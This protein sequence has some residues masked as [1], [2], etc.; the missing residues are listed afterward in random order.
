[1]QN[2][3]AK[4]IIYVVVGVVG[5]AIVW[6]IG[7]GVAVLGVALLFLFVWLGTFAMKRIIRKKGAAPK[8]WHGWFPW[9][10]LIF[11]LMPFI[12]AFVAGVTATL[13]SALDKKRRNMILAWIGGALSVVN[14]IL[15]AASL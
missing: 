6:S 11:W 3:T 10:N 2:K 7:E 4:T 12:G 9:L 14:T 1:M 5:Y 15:S 13:P 8:K